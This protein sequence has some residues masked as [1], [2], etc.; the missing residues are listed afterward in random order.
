MAPRKAGF[1]AFRRIKAAIRR[2]DKL[3]L[4]ATIWQIDEIRIVSSA[5]CDVQEE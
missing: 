4:V 2:H 5:G 3:H 1:A